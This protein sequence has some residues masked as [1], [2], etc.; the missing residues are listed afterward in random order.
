MDTLIDDLAALVP[1]ATSGANRP[2]ANMANAIERHPEFPDR[3]HGLHRALCERLDPWSGRRDLLDHEIG[4]I[5]E[6]CDACAVALDGSWRFVLPIGDR[7]EH[8]DRRVP[9][10]PMPELA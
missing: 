10:G 1:P 2:L 9:N 7:H 4:W 8:F 6:R 3:M 5:V